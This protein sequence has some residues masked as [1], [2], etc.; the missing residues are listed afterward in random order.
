MME[1]MLDLRELKRLAK[2]AAP[3][4]PKPRRGS[5]DGGCRHFAS[6]YILIECPNREENRLDAVYTNGRVLFRDVNVGYICR[7]AKEWMSPGNGDAAYRALLLPVA[8]LK[9]IPVGAR[10]SGCVRFIVEDMGDG[11]GAVSF[12]QDVGTVGTIDC[13][14]HGGMADYPEWRKVLPEIKEPAEKFAVFDPVA[15]S[16]VCN[17]MADG[18]ADADIWVGRNHNPVRCAA[19]Q[20]PPYI[21][22]G[23]CDTSMAVMMPKR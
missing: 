3:L 16:A 21:W 2:C 12:G 23:Y 9:V 4:V 19:G 7:I 10:D 5:G 13:K 8:A 1:G 11:S 6:Q 17:F 20:N 14:L 18:W 22:G 15:Y